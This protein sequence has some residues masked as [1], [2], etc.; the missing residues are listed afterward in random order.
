MSPYE[1]INGR[2][3]R[4]SFDWN[5]PKVTMVLEKLNQDKAR[6]IATRMHEALEKGKALMVDAQAKKE[7]DVNRHWRPID[8]D[9]KDKVY[10]STKNWKTQRPSQ[11]LDHQM[12][13]PFEITK[14]IGNSYEVK[15]LETMKVHNVF[16][17]DRLWKAV[18]DP[19]VGQ[20]NDPPPP[21]IVTIEEE[22]EVQEVLASKLVRGKLKYRVKWVG[23]DEDL[24]WYPASNLKYSPAKLRDFHQRNKD[25]PGPPRKLQEWQNAWEEG[26]DEYEDLDDDKPLPPRLRASFFERGG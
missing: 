20:T 7:W 24:D 2:L 5:T 3:P 10:I 1:L 22:W 6:Q 15:L 16:S 25:Q 13:G 8:F 11:K 19:L 23:H 21:I 17:P 14:K 18:D 12:A 4:T 9:V 26:R